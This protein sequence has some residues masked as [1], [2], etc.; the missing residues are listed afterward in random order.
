VI[1][2]K[3]PASEPDFGAMIAQAIDL[4]A[5]AAI[6]VVLGVLY[7]G[8]LWLTIRR[9]PRLKHPMLWLLAGTLS[10][11]ALVLA[12]FLLVSQGQWARLV[13]CAAG[14]VAAWIFYRPSSASRKRSLR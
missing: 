11:L 13:A 8:R 4:L 12:A 3:P 10:R 5:F 1:E 7:Y 2:I 6:G 14:V 9:L